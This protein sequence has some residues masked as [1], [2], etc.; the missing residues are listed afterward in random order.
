MLY[1]P[2]SWFDLSS[3]FPIA[4][5]LALLMVYPMFCAECH[6]INVWLVG[7]SHPSEKYDFVSWDYEIPNICKN[8]PN[9]PNHQ[10]DVY[11]NS[12]YFYVVIS[13]WADLLPGMGGR[14]SPPWELATDSPP[15]LRAWRALPGRSHDHIGLS[16][17]LWLIILSCGVPYSTLPV[18]KL[19]S[20]LSP[21]VIIS[22]NVRGTQFRQEHMRYR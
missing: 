19:L 17:G 21:V 1:Y 2:K 16:T 14:N 15:A 5:S 13:P 10:P 9:V 20:I 7:F 4:I 11:F 12:S 6:F 3:W 18:W 22:W 8:N